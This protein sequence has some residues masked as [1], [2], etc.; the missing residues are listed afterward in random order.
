MKINVNHYPQTMSFD[1]EGPLPPF[2]YGCQTR[3]D[4]L[5]TALRKDGFV[6][7]YHDIEDF[8]VE[9]VEPKGEGEVWFVGS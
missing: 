6:H 9:V 3:R 8:I 7:D 4:L 2:S 5:H 1:V